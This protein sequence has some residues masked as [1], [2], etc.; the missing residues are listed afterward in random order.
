MTEEQIAFYN[1]LIEL[2][3]EQVAQAFIDWHGTQLLTEDFMDNV[4]EEYFGE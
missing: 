3:G 1:K 4:R 2:T